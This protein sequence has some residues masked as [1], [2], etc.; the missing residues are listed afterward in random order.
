MS[1]CNPITTGI[2]RDCSNNL[3]GV[4]KIF[5]TDFVSV[6]GIT[7]SNGT[8]TN[9][10]LSGTASFWQFEF[11]KNTSNY[12]EE[13][14]IS[15]ENGS[16]FYKTTVNLVIPRREVAKRNTLA[17]L[18]SGLKNLAVIIYDQ[19]GLYWYVGKV[20]GANITAL[21]GGSGTKKEDANSYA[22]TILSEEPESLFE[23]SSTIIDAIT[24]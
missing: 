14:T 5:I 7:S 4:Q 19:N 24:T 16:I 13:T 2:L 18:T 21:T 8:I 23:V 22:I 12:S 17:L 6:S 1:A 9:L 20:N 10:T 3:G 11:N 15:Q